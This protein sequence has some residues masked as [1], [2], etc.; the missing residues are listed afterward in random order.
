MSFRCSGKLQ[1]WPTPGSISKKNKPAVSLALNRRLQAC[2]AFGILCAIIDRRD[3]IHWQE[4]GGKKMQMLLLEPIVQKHL[5]DRCPGSESVSIGSC[6]KSLTRFVVLR[7][8]RNA[9]IGE[10]RNRKVLV[11]FF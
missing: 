6:N 1:I 9:S 10:D 7:S 5:F 3:L 2:Y 8:Q 4:D 11:K